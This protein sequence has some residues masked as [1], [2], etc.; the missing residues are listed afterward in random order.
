MLTMVSFAGVTWCTLGEFGVVIRNLM[1]L[2]YIKFCACILHKP[3]DDQEKEH[4]HWWL[5][6]NG[7][8]NTDEIITLMTVYDSENDYFKE[9]DTSD[10]FLPTTLEEKKGIVPQIHSMQNG[11]INSKFS[12]WYRYCLHDR[13][14]LFA[15]GRQTRRYHYDMGDFQVTSVTEFRELINSMPLDYST[16]QMKVAALIEQGW[17]WQQLVK[18]SGFIDFQHIHQWHE[19]YL[20]MLSNET[21]RS[22]VWIEP[23]KNEIETKQSPQLEAPSNSESNNKEDDGQ[24][25][26]FDFL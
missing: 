12:D 17:T 1:E 25:S 21:N 16:V 9:K 2:G 13:T 20:A 7:K 14:Y 18:S 6:P 15:H 22:G 19:F 23:E 10:I 11:N 4:I 3:E 26:I 24:L 5:V 8:V